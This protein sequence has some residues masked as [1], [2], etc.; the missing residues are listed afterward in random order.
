MNPDSPERARSPDEKACPACGE[1]IKT[2][3]VKCRFCGED[4]E[5]FVRMREAAIE[6]TLFS[7]RPAAL[8]SLGRWTLAIVTLGLAGLYFWLESLSTRFE[9]STQRVR[10]ERGIFSKSRQ[11]TELFRIDD[12]A[13]EQPLGMRLAG[14]A[15][16]T[17]RSSDRTTPEI[18]LY[19]IPDLAALSEKLRQSSQ[20]ERE[21]R[22]IRVWAQ[23]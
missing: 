21:R 3:A 5:A 11:D 17:L 23:A 9:I 8:Y 22:G 18:R 15:R 1:T 19:G 10:V 4:I 14:H 13:L 16:L 7:G 20:R 6:T 2:A 12:F